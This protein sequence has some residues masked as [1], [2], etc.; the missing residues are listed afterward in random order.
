MRRCVY[1]CFLR[2]CIVCYRTFFEFFSYKEK[3]PFYGEL[4]K[5]PMT[6]KIQCS[7][8][9]RNLQIILHRTGGYLV[10][11]SLLN[12][13]FLVGD[14]NL[15]NF[16]WINQIPLSADQLYLKIY[17]IVNDLFFTQV[18]TFATRDK[19]ILDLVLTSTPDLVTD[20]SVSEGFLHSDR[21]SISFRISTRPT[22]TRV[23]PKEI[24]DFKKADMK[25]NELK[26][27]LSYISWNVAML[28]DNINMNVIKWEDLFWAAVN[29]FVPRKRVRDKQTP[30]WIEVKALCR[31]KD[32][33]NRRTL[34]TKTPRPHRQF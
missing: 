3:S 28:D 5:H 1:V 13:I 2:S 18:D 30:P 20:V 29:E 11:P 6:C 31:K 10:Q 4:K 33:A 21:L 16:D 7:S 15:L 17:E 32:K 9:V 19:N 25:L 12:K 22:C 14:F 27:T 8:E 23:M 34:T 26:K 24:L